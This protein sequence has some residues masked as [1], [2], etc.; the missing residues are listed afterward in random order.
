M[1]WGKKLTVTFIVFAGMMFYLVYR[2]L[3]TN[4]EL[5]DKDYYKNELRY[6]QVIDG[7]VHTNTLSST[8]VIKQTGAGIILQMPEEMKNK[9]LTGFVFFYCAYDSGKDKK[10]RLSPDNN[11]IQAFTGTVGAGSYTVKIDWKQEGV[12]YYSEKNITIL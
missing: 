12:N 10:F 8:P 1:N 5:V 7:S 2:S 4:F 3:S 6:Q 11:G 9:E